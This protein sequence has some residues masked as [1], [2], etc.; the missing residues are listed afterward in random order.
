MSNNAFNYKIQMQ[1]TEQELAE[2]RAAFA[3]LQ[4]EVVEIFLEAEQH[5]GFPTANDVINRIRSM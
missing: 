4:S 5:S 1:L 2:F 3:E